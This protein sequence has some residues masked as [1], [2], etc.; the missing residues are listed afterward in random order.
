LNSRKTITVSKIGN[1]ISVTG[2]IYTCR[3]P[4]VGMITAY[5]AEVLN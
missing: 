2:V 5:K 3:S 4:F 1:F